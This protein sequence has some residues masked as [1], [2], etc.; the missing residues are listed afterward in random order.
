MFQP[1][2]IAAVVVDLA[3]Q[4]E[5]IPNDLEVEIAVNEM[6]PTTR[7]EIS[8]LSPLVFSIDSGAL[9][10]TRDPRSFSQ[11]LATN[12]IGRLLF[13]YLDRQDPNF[14]A[15]PLGEPTDLAKRVAW[16]VYC[17]GRV[18]R[19]GVR[20]YRPKHLYNFRNRLGFS[21]TADAKFDSL[22]QGD[23]LAWAD[24]EALCS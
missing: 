5:G 15:P 10:D 8:S 20:V 9:E 4:I 13:E 14:A 17:Y 21:D 2:Q 24:I 7:M 11:E 3:R 6:N 16:D 22:W 23:G 1:S 12:S 19:L 18:S